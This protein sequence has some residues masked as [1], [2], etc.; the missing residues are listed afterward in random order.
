MSIAQLPPDHYS[1]QLLVFTWGAL[2]GSFLNVVI[3]RLPRGMSLSRPA[4]HCF[5]CK[6]PI[7]FFH[8]VPILS[9]LILRGRCSHCGERFSPRYALI[10]LTTAALSLT[11]YR[12]LVATLPLD[13][14]T[15]LLLVFGIQFVLIASL[16]AVTFI[17]LDWFIIPNSITLPGIALGLSLHGLFSRF[18]HVAFHE[19]FLGLFLG[20]GTILLLIEGYHWLTG[21]EGMG[22]GDFKLM[23]MI[24]A[25]LGWQSLPFV[26]F[27]S[28]VQGVLFAAVLRLLRAEPALPPYLLED[29][30]EEAEPT[31]EQPDRASPA[32]SPD[33]EAAPPEPE[34]ELGSQ[35]E[36]AFARMVM[37]FGPFL[38][39]A[40]IEYIFFGD[41]L[42]RW[43]A[44]ISGAR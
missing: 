23:A 14:W 8:N 41:I 4:S 29:P 40:A 26:F 22:G 35:S 20:G 33:E 38:A 6:T 27:A 32:P 31:G 28:S 39:L 43:F 21:R 36:L 2:W 3:V 1:F 16:I 12:F 18:T 42:I 13:D 19:S 7:P 37:P 15:R 30:H 44:R 24:G 5:S 25:F 9:Y 17:D 10:E 34:A 11:L